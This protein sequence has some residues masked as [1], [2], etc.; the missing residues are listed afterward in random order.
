M[1]SFHLD[2]MRSDAWL[3]CRAHQRPVW[4]VQEDIGSWASVIFFI[5]IVNTVGKS[6]PPVNSQSPS[7]NVIENGITIQDD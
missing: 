3:L 2:Q 5:S 4:R 7:T 1:V 6:R